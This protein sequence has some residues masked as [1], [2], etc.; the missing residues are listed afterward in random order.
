MNSAILHPLLS[1]ARNDV[2]HI[3]QD[4]VRRNKGM[5]DFWQDLTGTVWDGITGL[6][7]ALEGALQ[8]TIYLVAQL[9]ETLALIVRASIGDVSW[10]KV[11][12]SLGEVFKDVGTIMVYLD[13]ARQSFDWL[14]QAPLTAHC[15]NELDRFTGGML[16]TAKN[17][18]TLPGRALRGDPI[19][20]QE[21][22]G[23]C[24]FII[25][26]CLVVFTAG[27][28]VAVG[29]M[30]GTMV[31]REIC[32]HQTE[33]K[34]A[35]MVTFQILGAAAG[36]WG[37]ALY[38]SG[39]SAAEE[40]A[41]LDGPEAYNAYIEQQAAEGTLSEAEQNAWL[42]GDDA[43][44]KF[45]E[46]EAAST[47]AAS[48]T[49][50]MTHLASASQDYLTRVGIDQVTKQAVQLCNQAG[51]TGHHECEILA[52]VAADYIKSPEGQ[53]WSEFLSSEIAKIGAEEIMLQWFPQTSK[54]YQAIHAK[55]QLRFVDV[56]VDGGS[57]LTRT[58]DPKTFLLAAGALAFVFMEASS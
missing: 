16:T 49:S 29:A 39:F 7:K 23:D 32:K 17:V 14:S 2:R 20:K 25:Q 43:Y 1:P 3:F 12:D 54:E 13:P 8:T 58:I 11:L 22:L 19:S 50:F 9:G 18:S 55:W 26:V 37:Q 28:W 21:L 40:A 31:G 52:E 53:E 27:A 24:I 44:A 47:T 10:D 15:F 45:L 36:G 34:D 56:P 30:I 51:V 6:T 38:N 41:W 35:C 46:R 48:S 33:A 4:T 5:G 42:N 57:V